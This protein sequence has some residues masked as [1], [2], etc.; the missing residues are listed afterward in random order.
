MTRSSRPKESK[1]SAEINVLLVEDGDTN[2]KLIK[3]MLER[4]GARVTT[5]EQRGDRRRTGA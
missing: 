5:A 4:A 2:R 1:I 3:L